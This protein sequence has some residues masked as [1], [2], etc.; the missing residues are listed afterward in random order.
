[1]TTTGAAAIREAWRGADIVAFPGGGGPNLNLE[2][3]RKERND[4]GNAERLLARHG[5]DILYVREVGWHAWDGLRFCRDGAEALIRQKA[6]ETARSVMEEVDALGS[7][8]PEDWGGQSA[9]SERREALA[10][11]SIASGNGARIGAMIAEAAPYVTVGP[12]EIDADTRVLN[13]LNGTMRLEG[14]CDALA[15]HDRADRLSKLM[16]VEFD[17]DAA[18]PRFLAF[19][20]RV[21]PCAAVRDFLQAWSGYALT[22]D[23]GEQKLCFHWGTGAN[24][25]SVFLNTRS[26]IMGPYAATLQFA[27]LAQNDRKRG[28][29]ATPDLARLPGARMVRVSETDKGVKLS[30]GF[31]KDVTGGDTITA[32]HLNHG[33]FE[34]KPE[35]K[36]D[37]QG[38]HKPLIRGADEG[39]WRRVLLV[40]WEVTIPPEERDP[41]L[42]AKLWEERAG[43]L[44]WMLD[45]ARIWLE[46]GLVVPDA[47]SAATSAFRADSDPLGRFI[48]SCIEVAAGE[49]V[50]GAQMYEAFK[51]WCAANAERLWSQTAVG[52][53]LPERGLRKDATGGRVRYRDVRLVNVPEAGGPP[54]EEP[55]PFEPEDL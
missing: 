55:P 20:E 13:L 52:R 34:F 50:G 42:P 22:G 32:R 41:T 23:T 5:Q 7:E 51:A 3:A 26:R 4:L 29:A 14:A 18:C 15:A 43:I 19:L 1:M 28:D 48:A 21:Q 16:D 31:V 6:H 33:F 24:G 53:A 45:G 37:L 36:L 8:D 9:L 40:P 47:V 46:Q 38:N 35:F 2:L 11:W 30:E 17:P 39:I 10:A 49:D 25:K 12:D 44:N 54:G 27:S